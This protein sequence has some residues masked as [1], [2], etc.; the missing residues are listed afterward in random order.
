[1]IFLEAKTV[2]R[3][4]YFCTVIS[5]SK[6]GLYNLIYKIPEMP[7]NS[8]TLED[9]TQDEII[10]YVEKVEAES[11]EDDKILEGML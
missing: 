8:H 7:D 6:K 9:W 11:T 10:E 2:L 3:K 1:M 4:D 5:G